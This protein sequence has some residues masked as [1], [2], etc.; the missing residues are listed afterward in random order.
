MDVE[1]NTGCRPG[2][3]E[4]FKLKFSDVDWDGG[5]ILIRGTKTGFR[6]V[7]LKPK[8]LQRLKAKYQGAESEYI[9]DYKGSPLKQAQKKF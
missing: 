8:F 3:T 1:L 7:D 6:V 2:E 9:V 4:L 5:K